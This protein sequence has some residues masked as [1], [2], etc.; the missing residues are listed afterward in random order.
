MLNIPYRLGIDLGSN[1]LGW[2]VLRLDSAGNPDYLVRLG[3]RIFSNGR[4]PK[5]GSSLAVVRRLARQQRRRRDRFLQRKRSMLHA[6]R[7]GGLFPADGEASELLKSL[8]PY[9]LRHR[10][11][12]EQLKPY[13]IGR[14]I[15][16]LNQR[17]GFR[18]SRRTDRG[19]D[20]AKEK[21]KISKAVASLRVKLKEAGVE[22]LGSLL[23]ARS[24]SGVGTR[25][26]T[27]GEGAKSYYD[28]Y[29]DRHMTAAEFDLLWQRQEAYAPDLLTQDLYT[30]LRGILLHQRPLRPVRPGRCSLDP[31]HDRA[32]SALPSVQRFRMLQEINNLRWRRPGETTEIAL[33]DEQR[34]ELF[35]ALERCT[36]KSFSS[37][38][39]TIGISANAAINLQGIK[40]DKLLGNGIGYAL[41]KDEIFGTRW[42]DLAPEEQD[43]LVIKLVDDQLD[44]EE[45]LRQLIENYGM[46]AAAADAALRVV[47]QD[48]YSRLSLRAIQRLLPWLEQGLTYD[49]AVIAAGY[50][51]T[52][53]DGDG[54]F[55]Q[56]PYY[57]QVL[58]R[59]VAFGSGK[60]EDSEETRY[61]RIANPSV[62]I[63]LNQLRHLVNALVKRYGTPQEVVLELTRDIKLGWQRAREIEAEQEKRQRDNEKLREDLASQGIPVTGEAML[64][65]R[66]FNEML[67]TDGLAAS[68]IY[69]GEQISRTR[70]FSGDI[71]I[72][73][74]LPYSR[75]LDDSI[76]NKALCVSRANRLKGNATPY[77]AFGSSPDGFSW[78]D[79]LERASRL[80]RNRFRRFDPEAIQR[81]DDTGGFL[82]RQITDTAYMSRLAR[83]YL[84]FVCPPHRVW[85]TTGQ[86]TGMLRAK[87]GLNRLLSHDDT[88]NRRDHR[89]HAVDAVVI[90]SIDRSL[91]QSISTAA[92]SARAGG[93][94]RLLADL[95][96]PWPSFMPGLENALQR[97]VISYRPDHGTAGALHNDTA[98]GAGRDSA[99]PVAGIALSREVRHYV[100][101]RGLA[102]KRPADIRKSLCDRQLA[103]NIASFLEAHAVD[104]SARHAALEEMSKQRN[105]RRVS[106]REN[107]TV[108]P[109]GDRRTGLPYKYVKGDGNYC[110]EIWCGKNGKWTGK[111]ESMFT[112][113]SP[114]YRIFSKSPGFHATSFEGHPLTMRL[115]V[116]DMVRVTMDAND[117]IWR[118][119]GLTE[120]EITLTHHLAAGDATRKPVHI[121]GIS[122]VMRV[123]PSKLQA[124]RGR[125]VFVDILGRVKDPGFKDVTPDSRGGGKRPIPVG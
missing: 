107:L 35:D 108:I 86:L 97:V 43:A 92:S 53:T 28:F 115:L 46:S 59:H 114:R 32:P 90:A 49:K 99:E 44:D 95:R 119:Q 61:G 57:G 36:T 18:S 101:L 19:E 117:V 4:K 104:K 60:T 15:V 52:N 65:L 33:S 78:D 100:P 81:F 106:V 7:Q 41:A 93:S 62:H 12:A 122:P 6:L 91:V 50:P 124:L 5:D 31:E 64:R 58:Q 10:G 30:K 88:K 123:A 16:H 71:E 14:A 17:R 51:P 40:R 98:Y 20:A 55:E 63:A 38:R 23:Y 109:L 103:E 54:S 11:L 39:K 76:A 22:S 112:A 68:C 45:L 70:L 26:R 2:A 24:Q 116:G 21:G 111:V 72:D 87:W 25:A 27:L 37:V 77:E 34:K 102:D 73:H 113:N 69:S 80:T 85:A 82:A 79:I 125:R 94:N 66:L 74:I 3:V 1:S 83:E 48:G 84:S 42:F 9:E 8:N 29:P 118:V 75:T 110:Y 96:H 13:E 105:V 121:P 89:H 67:G 56:L 120:G 47:T